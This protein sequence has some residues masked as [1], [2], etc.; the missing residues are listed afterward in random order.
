[1]INKKRIILF[2]ILL[3]LSVALIAVALFVPTVSIVAKDTSKVV[4]YNK[5]VSLVQYLIDAPFYLT[6]AF[7]VYFNATG[8]IWMATASILFN[9]AVIIGG[10]VMMVC[11][12]VE[13][14][15]CNVRN[16]ATKNNILAK[17]ISLFVG[18][19]TICLA[20]FATTSFVVTTMMANDYVSFDLSVAPFA[21]ISLSVAI[22][23]LAHLTG[24]REQ[25]Q[26][27]NKIKNSLGF[28]LSGLIALAGIG[29]LFIPQFSIEFGLGVTSLWDVGRAA[30]VISSDPYISN[31]M[32]EYPFGFSTW[33]MFILF[34]I[35]AFVFIYSTI[36][37]I[38]VLCGK[39]TSWLSSRVKRWS[40]A[41]LIVYS[42]IY[43]FVFC[44]LAVLWTSSVIIDG[45]TI[46]LLHPYAYALMFVP[47]LPYAFSTLISVNKKK[48]YQ[49]SI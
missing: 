23:V 49:Q 47:Y 6:D 11:C 12:I 35:C 43:L 13:L 44:Q 40:M 46:F 30:T 34:F 32:G 33:T 25:I 48:I 41:Y 15:A 17:K 20:I 8:P 10:L 7:A 24:K 18:W 36:G 22:I 2:S 1:M 39:S 31:T 9:F 45:T 42:I 28:A 16:F 21:L 19:L 3:V 38:R 5:A 26:T 29:L 27:P 37:F 4:V 14:C